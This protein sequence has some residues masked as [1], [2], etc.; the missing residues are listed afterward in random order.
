[1]T[2]ISIHMPEWFG[3]V[4]LF[5]ALVTLADVILGIYSIILKRRYWNK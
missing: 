5:L 1:M 2:T 4:I 3:Y